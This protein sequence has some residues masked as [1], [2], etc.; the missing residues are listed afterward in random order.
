MYD[1]IE[2]YQISE[3]STEECEEDGIEDFFAFTLGCVEGT[4][5]LRA[6]IPHESECK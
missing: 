1:D 4:D 5:T 3:H 6:K 2:E